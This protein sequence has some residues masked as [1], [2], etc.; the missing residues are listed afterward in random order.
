MKSKGPR[1]SNEALLFSA[2]RK[3]AV[4]LGLSVP[5]QA[6]ILGLSPAALAG[7]KAAPSNDPDK[8]DRMALFVSI[9][10]LAGQAFPG[11]RGAMGWLQ[12]A[13]TAS[14]FG[15]E[16]PLKFMLVGRF[17]N[18]LRTSDHLQVLVRVW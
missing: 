5:D 4:A 14:I 15:G 12:R 11:E 10:G 13:N 3:A 16:S 1:Q 6:A 18:L 9:Y 2:F 8:L 17:E 7:W